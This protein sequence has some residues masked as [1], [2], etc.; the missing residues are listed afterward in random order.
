MLHFYERINDDDDVIVG[1][2][3]RDAA[4]AATARPVGSP[5]AA[6]PAVRSVSDDR[7]AFLCSAGWGWVWNYPS[8]PA[9]TCSEIHGRYHLCL[10]C[11]VAH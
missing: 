1:L 6:I 7:D 5:V 9:A 4:T 3:R 10:L 2:L 8:L 11:D